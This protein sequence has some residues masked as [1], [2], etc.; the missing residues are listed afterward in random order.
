MLL[1]K[2][3]A[4]GVRPIMI[5]TV[6]WKVC[7]VS[8]YLA[9]KPDLIGLLDGCQY[10]VAVPNGTSLMLAHLESAQMTAGEKG[11]VYARLDVSNV[12]GN[13]SRLLVRDSLLAACPAARESWGP[14]LT[15]S[16]ATPSFIP[17]VD[18]SQ[19]MHIFEELPQGNPLSAFLFSVFV[20]IQLQLAI[21]KCDGAIVATAYVDD[22]VLY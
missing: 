14:W 9:I 22:I 17:S 7:I 3:S 19:T 20:S 21:K 13:V 15:Q 6:A 12:F 4:S 5:S 2:P 1:N 18:A 16:L 10:G 8:A 11:I